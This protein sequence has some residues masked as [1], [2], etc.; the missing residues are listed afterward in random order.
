MT[1][2]TENPDIKVG[3]RR[4]SRLP[5]GFGIACGEKV[6]DTFYLCEECDKSKSGDSKS[7]VKLPIENPDIK[8]RWKDACRW[9][10]KKL[11]N[12]SGFCNEEH[13][14]KRLQTRRNYDKKNRD[15]LNANLREWKK[16]KPNVYNQVNKA[17][18]EGIIAVKKCVKCGTD[19]RLE[20]HHAD[21]S[22]PLDVEILCHSCHMGVHKQL[23]VLE[24]KKR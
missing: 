20:S 6:E 9:C 16:D 21:Y 4:I 7:F 3:C 18:K 15:K 14:Q 2:K 11:P 8:N 5:D 23:R 24:G 10:G 17:K 1:K 22:R 13:R 19:K 12:G